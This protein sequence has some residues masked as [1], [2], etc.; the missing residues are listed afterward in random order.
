MTI[1]FFYCYFWGGIQ[2]YRLLMESRSFDDRK[3]YLIIAGISVLWLPVITGMFIYRVIE[4][5]PWVGKLVIQK[6]KSQP[7]V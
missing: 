7:L 3:T 1:L 5:I 4:A 2:T 6:L